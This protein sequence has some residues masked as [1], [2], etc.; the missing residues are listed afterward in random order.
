MDL[1]LVPNQYFYHWFNSVDRRLRDQPIAK[2]FFVTD[3]ETEGIFE[4]VES[5]PSPATLAMHR[6]SEFS[7]DAERA[8]IG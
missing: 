4:H 7:S 6:Q 5:L 8:L 2:T 1:S 3:Y